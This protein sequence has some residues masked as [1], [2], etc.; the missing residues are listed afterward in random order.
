VDGLE[1]VGRLLLLGGI[2]L[3]VLGVILILAPNL[4]FIGRLPG[5]IRIETDNVRIYLPLGTM[6]IVSV[7]LTV[8]FNLF[9][10]MG[11]R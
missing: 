3:G 10:G 9:G 4:P 2:I 7:V 11:R 5:D 8:L 1:G 6:L